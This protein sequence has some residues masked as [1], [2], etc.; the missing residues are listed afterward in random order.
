[1][2]QKWVL[3]AK[4]GDVIHVDGFPWK[5]EA[6]E[7]HKIKLVDE[8]SGEIWRVELNE[9][10]AMDIDLGDASQEDD[11]F[12]R[13]DAFEALD[14]DERHRLEEIASHL[15]EIMTSKRYWPGES[16]E[17]VEVNPK[18][19]PGVTM[20]TRIERKVEELKNSHLNYKARTWWK[21]LGLYEL[22]DPST[23]VNFKSPGR[24]SEVDPKYTEALEEAL[25]QF[26]NSGPLPELREVLELA[27]QKIEENPAY[28]RAKVPS[29]ATQYRFLRDLRRKFGIF[30][31][32]WKYAQSRAARPKASHKRPQA[33]MPGERLQMDTTKANVTV[34]DYFGNEFRPEISLVQD[35]VTRM[36]DALIVSRSTGAKEIAALML[37]LFTPK[38]DAPPLSPEAHYNLLG[39]NARHLLKYLEGEGNLGPATG[40]IVVPRVVVIDRGKAFDNTW[41]RKLAAVMGFSIELSRP[42]TPTDKPHVER[43]LKTLNPVL[44]KLPGY[45]GR[46]VVEQGKKPRK[47]KVRHEE[48][49]TMA[50]LETVLKAWVH[51]VYHHR[52]HK[53][54][55]LVEGRHEGI[56]VSIPAE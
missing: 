26:L 11:T 20:T 35:S 43:V 42:R 22:N 27:L 25:T 40:M 41:F 38:P 47:K 54:L 48:L 33:Y 46:N 18:Y 17:F 16:P 45:T 6:I 1:V 37:Q 52:P 8:E 29:L 36:I 13:L 4:P 15:N 44:A 24:P 39:R 19:G 53:G 10:Q 30:G 5:V 14:P 23:L 32:N 12:A 51:H 56:P 31:S 49:L 50:E 28:Q 3:T 7:P 9:L 55:V 34:R 2:K 21:F